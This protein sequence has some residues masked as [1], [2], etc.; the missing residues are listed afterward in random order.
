MTIM[1]ETRT[2]LTTVPPAARSTFRRYRPGT[3]SATVETIRLTDGRSVRTDLIRLNP[4]LECYSLDLQGAAP[5]GTA[6]YTVTPWA[7]AD[8]LKDCA[9]EVTAILRASYPAVGLG[10]LS[11]RMRNDGYPLGRGNLQ[12]HEAIAATQ[13]ALW[14]V[15]N[16]V[17]LDTRPVAAPVSVAVQRDGDTEAVPVAPERPAWVGGITRDSG[18]RLHVNMAE[19]VQLGSYSV[20]FASRSHLD[21]VRVQL[22]RSPDGRAWTPVPSSAVCATGEHEVHKVLGVGATLADGQG[23]GYAHYRVVITT[24]SPTESR[25]GVERVSLTAAGR[26]AYRNPERVVHL[27]EYLLARVGRPAAPGRK[28]TVC[29][30]GANAPGR[31]NH[32]VGPILVGGV[33]PGQRFGLRALDAGAY[34]VD[35]VGD[36]VFGPVTST[37]PV[38]L[39]LPRRGQS[40]TARMAVTLPQSDDLEPQLLLGAAAPGA[41]PQFTPVVRLVSAG[42]GADAMFLMDIAAKSGRLERVD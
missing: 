3:F 13:A 16:D 19:R 18:V 2:G 12:A 22:E 31:H 28:V 9:P 40:L 1:N 37:E 20:V 34:V 4:D 10:E 42:R 23:R 17:D 24:D 32:V 11:A 25:I 30:G 6:H 36:P 15:T 21:G 38:F 8:P 5:R 27:Y 33:A 41:K 14:H 7:E 29:L 35:D 39:R 26:P